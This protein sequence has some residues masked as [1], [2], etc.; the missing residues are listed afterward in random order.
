MRTVEKKGGLRT[1]VLSTFIK[2]P[3]DIVIEF[4]VGNHVLL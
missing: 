4:D 2:Q 1:T 3:Q